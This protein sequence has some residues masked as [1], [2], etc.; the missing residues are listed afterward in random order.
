MG[1]VRSEHMAERAVSVYELRGDDQPL[2]TCFYEDMRREVEQGRGV[3]RIMLDVLYNTHV[4]PRGEEFAG[5]STPLVAVCHD[6]QKED[7]ERRRLERGR[8][9]KGVDRKGKG[10]D[11]GGQSGPS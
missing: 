10:V 4:A 11:R 5:D 9:G 1:H 2:V 7:R 8:K 6:L 3:G